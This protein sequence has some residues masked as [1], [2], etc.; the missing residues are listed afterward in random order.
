MLGGRLAPDPVPFRE[1]QDVP[2]GS[3]L[4]RQEIL[5]QEESMKTKQQLHADQPSEPK[6]E[7]MEKAPEIKQPTITTKN[8]E[9]FT[10]RKFLKIEGP[11]VCFNAPIPYFW[12]FS[13]SIA[14]LKSE[15]ANFVALTLLACYMIVR[16]LLRYNSNQ[17]PASAG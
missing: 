5:K 16:L 4:V 8:S 1:P 17:K 10:L 3:P 12:F 6:R 2:K 11:E 7:A 9:D 14:C 13:L 15:V